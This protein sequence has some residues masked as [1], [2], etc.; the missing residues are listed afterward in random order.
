M[1][2]D[3]NREFRRNYLP[4]VLS[5]L[6]ILSAL[7]G[8]MLY[9]TKYRKTVICKSSSANGIY[10]LEI[11]EIGEPEFP[12]GKTDCRCILL[13]DGRP[14]EKVDFYVLNDGKH[15]AADQFIVSWN[16][17]FAEILVSAEEQE[18]QKYILNYQ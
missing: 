7:T 14:V 5:L 4:A 17:E 12:Y 6:L 18:D 9:R 3:M 15:M 8:I 13:K 10:T 2:R 16:D 11:C 1:R